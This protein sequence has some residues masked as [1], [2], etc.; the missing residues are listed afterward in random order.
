MD[1]HLWKLLVDKAVLRT[2]SRDLIWYETSEGPA[3]TLSFGTLIDD[4]TTLNIWGYE[5]NYSYELCLIKQTTGEPFEERKRATTKKNS[6]GV[7]FSGLFEATQLQIK[8]IARDRAFTAVMEYLAD[9]TVEDLEKQDEFRDQ[10]GALGDY[11]YFLYS[12]DEKILAAVKD[13]T[14][15]GSITWSIEDGKDRGEEG[16]YFWAEIGD[17]LYLRLHQ[18]Q[19]PRR[20]AGTT[21]YRFG[22]GATSDEPFD[23]E[24][25]LSPDTKKQTRPLWLIADELHTIISKTIHED[26]AKF[27]QI[28]RDN[29]I[30]D[31]L[32]SLDNHHKEQSSLDGI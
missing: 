16:Q 30:H 20:A 7:N 14:A 11:G 31:I 6:D 4:S 23:V 10:W 19:T 18:S 3:N 9:P 13:M 28:V 8:A 22:I 25:K 32:A 24:V 5:S 29:I 1:A 12:H 21:S 26:E 17:L 2:K 15:A 27:N